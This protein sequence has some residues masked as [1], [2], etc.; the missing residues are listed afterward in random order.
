MNDAVQPVT[1]PTAES[2]GRLFSTQTWISATF[3]L[4]LTTLLSKALGVLRDALVARYF[5]ASAQVDAFMVAVTLP[6]LVGAIG[7]AFSAA[8]IPLYRRT[9][10]EGRPSQGPRLAGG[11]FV[12]TLVLSSFVTAV[13]VLIPQYLIGVAA[14]DLP[15]ETA[16]LA[17]RLLRL[18][19]LLVIGLNLFHMLGAIYNAREHF[20]IPAYTDLASNVFVLLALVL[21][22]PTLGIGALALGMVAGSLIVV[23]GMLIPIVG[24]R[25]ITFGSQ[26]WGSGDLTQLMTL[27]APVFV[28][29]LLSN[30]TAIVENYFGS[31]LDPG[32]ISAL[33]FARRL[34]IMVVSLLAINI[35]RAV[36]PALSRFASEQSLAQA[37]DLFTK[38]TYQFAVTF[39]PISIAFIYFREDIIRVVFLRGAFDAVAAAK[40]STAFLYY[41]VG[42]PLATAVPIFVRGCYAFGDTRTP[43]K[44][45]LVG[46]LVLVTLNSLLTPLLGI[47]GI[48]LSTDLAWIPGLVWMAT[49]LTRRMGPFDFGM[50]T[51]TVGLTLVCGVV[52]LVPLVGLQQLDI[53]R[54]AV[55][56]GIKTP[57]YLAC[58]FAVGR[59]LMQREIRSLWQMFR[60]RI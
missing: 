18:L 10:A 9:V 25:V 19:A 52:A 16:A 53:P 29:E 44:A 23:A 38:L 57:V 54:G 14:P 43:L 5:G 4:V 39:V 27:A 21:L 40:T 6:A 36:F 20:R 31:R 58:Y 24:H 15:F 50:L 48:V 12:L 3:I 26:V 30:V 60:P 34:T 56:L 22:S 35:A 46:L 49:A 28:V 1:R 13:M 59:F 32:T 37:K 55:T 33:G 45:M 7:L 2:E 47:V 41:S 11:A 51:K 17:A 8:F 42:L